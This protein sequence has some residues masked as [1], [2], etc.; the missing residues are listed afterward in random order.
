V[1]ARGCARCDDGLV[2][3]YTTIGV[4]VCALR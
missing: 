4:C 1:A 3:K 2:P